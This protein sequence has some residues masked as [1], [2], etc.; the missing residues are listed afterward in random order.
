[1]FFYFFVKKYHFLSILRYIAV[2]NG[3]GRF[4]GF[5][6]CRRQKF[7]R[8]PSRNLERTFTGCSYTSCI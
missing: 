6:P 8:I 5:S 2:R 1:M 4:S 3:F 7:V